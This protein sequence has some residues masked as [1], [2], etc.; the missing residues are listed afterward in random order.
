MAMAVVFGTVLGHVSVISMDRRP[1]ASFRCR[2]RHRRGVDHEATTPSPSGKKTKRKRESA[3]VVAA[4]FNNVDDQE[5]VHPFRLCSS[6]SVLVPHVHF[7]L[8]SI[9]FESSSNTAPAPSPW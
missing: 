5:Q 9:Q 8:V 1:S 7:V 6:A 2:N 3:E 4:A